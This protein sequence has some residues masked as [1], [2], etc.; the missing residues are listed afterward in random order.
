MFLSESFSDE[1]RSINLLVE[2]SAFLLR[3]CLLIRRACMVVSIP[4]PRFT[5]LRETL[6]P[7]ETRISD[8]ALPSD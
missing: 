2:V 5:H 8:L 1:A 4:A 3:Y 6:F 7:M